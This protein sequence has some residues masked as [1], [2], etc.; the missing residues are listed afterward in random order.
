MRAWR[1]Y[2][3]T[4][5]R[6]L[7]GGRGRPGAIPAALGHVHRFGTNVPTTVR[8]RPAIGR[9]RSTTPSAASRGS[10]GREHG[11]RVLFITPSRL[12]LVMTHSLRATA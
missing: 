10:A 4:E 7:L 11:P 2:S 5:V 6:A 9:H 8:A 12:S 3:T 1:P